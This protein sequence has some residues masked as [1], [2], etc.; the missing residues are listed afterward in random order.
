MFEVTCDPAQYQAVQEA[1]AEGRIAC[2]VAELSQ[3]PS[4]TVDLDADQGRKVLRFMEANIHTFL[5]FSMSSAKASLDAIRNIEG[6]S[7]ATV[8][9]RNGTD[10]GIQV[11][12]MGD[13][14][15]TAP[16]AVPGT[17][18]ASPRLP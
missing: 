5:G 10:F 11:S 9:A 8:M 3:I 4:N 17:R 7:I 13:Q 12:A 2:E 1:L 15:F 18:A 16:A 6:C 14:W